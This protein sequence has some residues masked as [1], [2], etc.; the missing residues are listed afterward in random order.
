MVVFVIVDYQWHWQSGKLPPALLIP[1]VVNLTSVSP[2]LV[3]ILGKVRTLGTAA[4]FDT[5]GKFTT[6]VKDGNGS[7]WVDNI[8]KFSKKS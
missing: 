3:Y 8:C 1:M 2:Q 5:G 6:G 4:I 7:P